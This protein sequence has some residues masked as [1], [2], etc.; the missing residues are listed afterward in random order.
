MAEGQSPGKLPLCKFCSLDSLSGA[1]KISNSLKGWHEPDMP[2][3][4]RH[5]TS[6]ILIL[7]L[8]SLEKTID[9]KGPQHIYFY[10]IL[11]GQVLKA[12]SSQSQACCQISHQAIRI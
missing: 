9:S 4:C 2:L 12:L 11:S 5:Y 8:L 3:T 7:W 10:A 1:E 6:V